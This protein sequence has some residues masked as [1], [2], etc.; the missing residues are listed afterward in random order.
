MQDNRSDNLSTARGKVIGSSDN[1]RRLGE[2]R[3]FLFDLDDTIAIYDP[4]FITKSLYKSV[5]D[6]TVTLPEPIALSTS[7]KLHDAMHDGSQQKDALLEIIDS[8]SIP[9]FWQGFTDYLHRDIQPEH[10]R[11]DPRLIKFINFALRNHFH[12]GVI[13]NSTEDAGQR[14]LSIMEDVSGVDL[15]DD[16][17]F[18]GQDENRKP[19]PAALSRYEEASGR[20]IDRDRAAYIGNA[21]SDLVFAQ[22][23]GM[24]PILIDYSDTS[25]D[26][27]SKQG[28]RLLEDSVVI[29]DFAS[30][31]NHVELLRPNY[32]RQISFSVDKSL[33]TGEKVIDRKSITLDAT[34]DMVYRIS[35]KATDEVMSH[36]PRIWQD[37][38]EQFSDRA[39][40]FSF[41]DLPSYQHLVNEANGAFLLPSIDNMSEDLQKYYNHNRIRQEGVHTTNRGAIYYRQH[42]DKLKSNPD[43]QLDMIQN[44]VQE[45]LKLL[46]SHHATDTNDH[47]SILGVEDNLRGNILSAYLSAVNILRDGSTMVNGNTELKEILESFQQAYR[48]S[49]DLQYSHML[50]IDHDRELLLS[51]INNQMD[52]FSAYQDMRSKYNVTPK[53]KNPEIDNPLQIAARANYICAQYTETDQL[54]GLTSGGIELAEVS[55]LLY[56]HRN[57]KD[58]DVLTYPIS[59]HNGQTMWSKDKS[60]HASQADIDRLTDIEMVENKHVV[61][62]EDNSNSGQTLE[63]VMDRV[64]SYGAASVHFAVVE[65]DPTRVLLHHVQQKAGSKH[66]IGQAAERVRP[67]ANYFH[68]DF[69]GAIGVVKILP[70]DNSFSKIIALDTANRYIAK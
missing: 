20:T 62:C 11:F 47:L 53:I 12:V 65:I 44:E 56:K 2:A 39:N 57:Q 54:I 23:T 14:V 24:V 1:L 19:K 48:A 26:I 5:K 60:P 49:V 30:L 46:E 69:I 67:I 45:A 59:V 7:K 22:N 8:G 38:D 13:S 70:Q 55:R 17:L 4:G 52:V 28:A 51:R 29:N 42:I 36:V 18:L 37:F 25:D 63:R 10:V 3:D 66:N 32:R 43:V 33:S 50:G 61:V 58:I 40:G 34:D 6:H 27:Q 41:V 16:A 9:S 64:K 15:R 31:K 35:H 68:P 21:V